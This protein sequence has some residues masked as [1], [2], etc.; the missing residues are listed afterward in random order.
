MNSILRR[1]PCQTW[2]SPG[3]LPRASVW[4]LRFVLLPA[5]GPGF[6]GHRGQPWQ[7]LA[8]C[9]LP[10][11]QQSGLI[12]LPRG[13]RWRARARAQGGS[14]GGEP[15]PIAT[16]AKITRDALGSA[17]ETCDTGARRGEPNVSFVTRTA[18]ETEPPASTRDGGSP[19][20]RR[21]ATRRRTWP[22]TMPFATQCDWKNQRSG[23][24]RHCGSSAGNAERAAASA[25]K[26]L[27]SP[28]A[29]RRRRRLVSP[30]PARWTCAV[31]RRWGAPPPHLRTRPEFPLAR[32]RARPRCPALPR[33]SLAS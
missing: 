4:R 9:Q 22:P 21:R 1:E 7:R 2:S 20:E 15:P 16:V 26:C 6:P 18:C 11:L 14:G 28:P 32:G 30:T 25:C 8:S 19:R 3:I 12:E 29:P 31:A 23:C 33:K 24:A 10:S 5:Q 27:D 13:L 17:P